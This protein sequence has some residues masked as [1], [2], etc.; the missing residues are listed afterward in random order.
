MNVNIKTEF[1]NLIPPL[2]EDERKQLEE[3]IMEEGVRDPLITWNGF[4]V[5]GHNRYEICKKENI[6]FKTVEKKFKDE[7]AVKLWIINNQ[8]G[9]RNLSA[10]DRTRLNLKKGDFFRAKAKENIRGRGKVIQISERLS[11]LHKVGEISGVSHDTVAKVKLIERHA[12]AIIKEQLSR[13]TTT[14]NHAYIV[15]KRELIKQNPQP[16]PKIPKGK[17]N[18]IYADPPWQYWAGGDKNQSKHY[19]TMTINEICN[20][21]INNLAAEDCILFLWTTSPQLPETFKVIEAW[22]FK[23]STMGFVWVKKNKKSP[24]WFFGL[25]NWT[26][27]N[28]E[29]CLIAVKGHPK[30]VSASVPQIIDTPIEEHSKKPDIVRNKIIELVGDLPRIELFARQE[31]KGWKSWGNEI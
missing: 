19:Q 5:D 6:P 29:Y 1:K 24:G 15:T 20:L 16:T 21:P 31:T 28:A 23:Y 12:P 9:R 2:S 26:R 8:L 7:E 11:T 14:I 27:S 17:Y 3:N 22:G 18:I 13:G 30:R 25:G 4:L 10:Y